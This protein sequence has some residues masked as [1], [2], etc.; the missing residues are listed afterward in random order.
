MHKL[1]PWTLCAI[2]LVGAIFSVARSQTVTTP[3]IVALAC[4]YNSAAQSISSG[5]Y[6]LVQC[7]SGGNIRL[8]NQSFIKAMSAATATINFGG[9]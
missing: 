4:A 3:V 7:D 1:L 5:Q 8:A 9:L 2:F 6:A